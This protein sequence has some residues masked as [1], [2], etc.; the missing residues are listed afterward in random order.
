MQFLMKTLSPEDF[1]LAMITVVEAVEAV[2]SPNTVVGMMEN[3]ETAIACSSKNSGSTM[4]NFESR[5]LY[6]NGINN[7][8]SEEREP[9]LRANSNTSYRTRKGLGHTDRLPRSRNG[10]ILWFAWPCKRLKHE[11]TSKRT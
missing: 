7:D 10:V 3:V 8:A 6:D 4:R 9:L 5:M 2:G 11:R 1:V